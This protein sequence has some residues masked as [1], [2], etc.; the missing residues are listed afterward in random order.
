MDSAAQLIEIPIRKFKYHFRPLTWLEEFSVVYPKDKNPQKVMLAHALVDIS[1]TP[2]P[3]VDEAHRMLAP[4]PTAVISRMFIV[5]RGNA[6]VS[7]KFESAPLYRAPEPSSYARRVKIQAGEQDNQ[8]ENVDRHLENMYGAKELEGARAIQEQILLA[9][10]D[11]TGKPRGAVRKG[12]EPESAPARAGTAAAEKDRKE[13]VKV[14]E[15]E[16]IT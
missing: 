15:R 5:Y 13:V 12:V 7:R 10:R 2:V 8:M 16:I 1:G 6:Q 3:S 11:E 4:L 9:S 14:G